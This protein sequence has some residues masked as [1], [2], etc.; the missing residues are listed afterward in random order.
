MF[1]C[2]WNLPFIQAYFFGMCAFFIAW[3]PVVSWFAY[4]KWNVKNFNNVRIT[5]RIKFRSTVHNYNV[6][7][8]RTF[9][10]ETYSTVE[11]M[12]SKE[13]IMNQSLLFFKEFEYQNKNKHLFAWPT[14]C[15]TQSINSW[16]STV[17]TQLLKKIDTI[18]LESFTC[19]H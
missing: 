12:E 9:R 18:Y 4:G 19:L 14:F 11:W 15:S 5:C 16:T 13:C 2:S 17:D 7:H 3:T 8:S 10:W 6:I 1:N